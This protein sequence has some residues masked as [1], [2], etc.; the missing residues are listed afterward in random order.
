ME[1]TIVVNIYKEDYDVYVGRAGHGNDGYFGN[2][3]KS[4]NRDESIARFEQYFQERI[5]ND[6][7]YRRRILSLQGKVLGCFCKPQ[8]CHADIIAKYLNSIPEVKPIKLAVVGSRHF[9]DYEFMCSILKWYDISTIIS[10]GARGADTLAERYALEHN[11]P[12]KVFP[13]E[14]DK[15]GKRAGFLRNKSMVDAADE[16]TAFW[17]QKTPGTG[18]TVR[19]AEEAGKPVF[20]YWPPEDPL[21]ELS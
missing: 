16:I 8:K 2:P 17:D 11:I 5:K 4:S 10:G 13:A 1:P 7:E 3:F 20:I 14:W 12:F 9:E 6:P 19:F 21:L 15:Y 18:Y